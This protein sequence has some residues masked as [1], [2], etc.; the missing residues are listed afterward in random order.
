MKWML[1]IFCSVALVIG[2]SRV[3]AAQVTDYL[4]GAPDTLTITV[5]N[6]PNLS[7]K[8]SV[9]ADGT[10][11]F[12]LIGRISAGGLT[13]RAIESELRRRLGEGFL[14]NP[15]VSVS[16]ETYRSQQI[17]IVGEVRSPGAYPLTG[18]M[19]LIEALARA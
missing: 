16:V 14:K 19:T 4:V 3:A 6:Q 11:T 7:G 8:F 15:Q 9:E 13:L 1:T 18:N 10:F 12:P 5:W 2:N 17:F